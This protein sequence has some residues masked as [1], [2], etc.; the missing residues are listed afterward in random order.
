MKLKILA[1]GISRDILGGAELTIELPDGGTV[2][3]L[4]TELMRRFP[5]FSKLKA[6][7]V[8]V[9]SEYAQPGQSLQERDEVALIPPVSGG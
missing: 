5:E 8:A 6:L 7:A 3:D 9:N 4:K 1:F 2:A